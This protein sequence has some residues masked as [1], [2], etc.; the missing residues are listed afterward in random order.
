V[1]GHYKLICPYRL[2]LNTSVSVGRRF[3]R[4][5]RCKRQTNEG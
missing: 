2:T 5:R 4:S 3:R 1:H